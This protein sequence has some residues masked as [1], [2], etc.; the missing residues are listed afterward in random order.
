VPPIE[1][2]DLIQRS[3]DKTDPRYTVCEEY[4]GARRLQ[5]RIA[6]EDK[7]PQVAGVI[8]RA[9]PF[10]VDQTVDRMVATIRGHGLHLFSQIDHAQNAAEVGLTM[11]AAQVL[12][13]GNPQSG[14]PLMIASPLLALELPLRV[15]VWQDGRG[16]TWI[17]YHDPHELATRYAVPAPLTPALAS[18]E[19]LVAEAL[20]E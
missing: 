12:I 2:L 15:L 1:R 3:L 11:P 6:V 13:F 10:S 20:G 8:T 18:I 4:G 7:P 17:S 16:H 19:P 5:R 9:S 14:T